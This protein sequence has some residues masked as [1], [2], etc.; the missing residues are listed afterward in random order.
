MSWSLISCHWE[1]WS[2]A[3]MSLLIPFAAGLAQE[4]KPGNIRVLIL[5]TGN[6][7]RSQMSAGFLQSWDARL[8]VHSAGTDPSPRVNPFAI[9]AMKEAGVDISGG[10]PKSVTQF[11]GQPFDYVITVCDDA[12]QNCPN[13]RGKVG[14]RLHIGFPD[15]ARATGTDAE[16]LET[17]RRVRENIRKRFREF[18]EMEVREKLSAIGPRTTLSED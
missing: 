17:F 8:E 4:A 3:S 14:K 11:L 18:Y 16:K 10:H 7:A 12:D 9:E 6:S 13:S 5:C 2:L 1:L 15:P